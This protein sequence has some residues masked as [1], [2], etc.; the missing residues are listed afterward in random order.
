MASQSDFT[1]DT[2]YDSYWSLIKKFFWAYLHPKKLMFFL[3]QFAHIIVAV[4]T[5][6]PPLIIREIIDEAIPR[7]IMEQ[8]IFL[9]L[10]A[11]GVYALEAG[12]RG[13]KAYYGHVVAQEIT[14]DM[15]NDLYSHYQRLNLG[16][17]DNKKTG[18]L[19][20]R[21]VDDLNRM[22][23]FVHHGPEALVGSLALLVGTV[24]VMFFL[25]VRLTLVSLIFVP[26]LLIFSRFM[27]K[28]MHMAFR[29]TRERKAIM[30]D[31]LEDNLAGIQI[32]KAFANEEEEYDRFAFTNEKHKEA[33]FKAIKYM[34]LLFPGSRFM[35]SFGILTVLSYG[36]YMVVL[37]EITV[38]TIVA[39]YGFLTQFRVPL[40][41]LVHMT[42]GLSRFFASAERFFH[43]LEI[44]PGIKERKG[45]YGNP[46]QGE[47]EFREV[48]FSY[49][50]GEKV[51]KGINFHVGKKESVALVGPSGAGKTSI[52]RL[53][54]RLYE[55]NSGQ[56]LVDGIDVRDWKVKDLRS[57]MAMVMQDDYL[58]SDSVAEN[59]AYGRPD[60]SREEIIEAARAANAH[61]FILELPQGYETPVGQRGLK[62]SGGQRQ[63]VSLARA[64][65]KDPSILILDEATSAVDIQTE[66]LI[67][68][69]IARIT[70]DRTT[71]IIA[72]RLS[73]I[74]NADEILF[75]DDGLVKER[76]THEELMNREGDYSRYYQL[77]FAR[78]QTV[79]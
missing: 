31:R 22:Q 7:G 71:F 16:F 48:N 76:G 46:V 11:L 69:A 18:E 74:R 54:P 15:R 65:L 72:H 5:L 19:M 47:V 32:I 75:I 41:Q 4:L 33:R 38:G 2:S 43:H 73:T 51:L 24:G 56:V 3:V 68:E 42:E 57:S 59:I 79:S 60:A 52:I 61:Q 64:F 20:S 67:Q 25:S 17:H 1:A 30:H 29:E 8:I 63:R 27:L 44:E 23:E 40:L 55:V 35:N 70:A 34:S 13:F 26:V 21:V 6:I 36:G 39:F 53:I 9:V 10:L 62:L 58:F 66:K 28:K 45:S 77:Q 49:N 37:G 12:I 50:A 78:E 14:R